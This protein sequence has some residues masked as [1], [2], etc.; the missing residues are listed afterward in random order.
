MHDAAALSLL[1]LPLLYC[2]HTSG[3]LVA[4]DEAIHFAQTWSPL[5]QS[6]SI[7]HIGHLDMCWRCRNWKLQGRK[8]ISYCVET[9]G[10]KPS[11]CADLTVDLWL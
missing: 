7:R 6:F 11:D 4:D 2:Q 1:S 3:G 10:Q 8:N 9:P 5:E